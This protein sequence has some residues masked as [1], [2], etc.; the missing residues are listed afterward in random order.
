MCERN[1]GEGNC[2]R[3]DIHRP[4]L[5]RSLPVVSLINRVLGD[6]RMI[7]LVRYQMSLC[8]M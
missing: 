3:V 6:F 4:V 5:N 8:Y 7:G 2:M 1:L